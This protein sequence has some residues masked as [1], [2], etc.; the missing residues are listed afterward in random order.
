MSN[1]IAFSASGL[2]VGAIAALTAVGFLLIYK[3]TGVGISS[4]SVPIS[5]SGSP[6]KKGPSGWERSDSCPGTSSPS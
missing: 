1:F 2:A 4:P 6:K 5:R 3:A